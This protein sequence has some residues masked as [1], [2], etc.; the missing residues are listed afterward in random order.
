MTLPNGK[1][2][3]YRMNGLL[4]YI[5]ILALLSAGYF[6]Y[7]RSLFGY[8]YDHFVE[9]I[10]ASVLTTLVFSVVLYLASFRSKSVLCAKGGNTGSTIYDFFIGRELNPR[11]GNFDF[12]EFCELYPGLIGWVVIDLAMACKQYELHGHVTNSMAMVCLFHGIYVADAL[13]FEKVRQRKQQTSQAHTHTHTHT[14]VHAHQLPLLF[15]E[16]LFT[17]A[18]D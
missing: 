11:L 3:Q 14:R 15:P 6:G 13:Y 12:K 10:T 9:L 1:R 4:V 18:R 17:D 5:V 2:L 16:M 7:D 8:V